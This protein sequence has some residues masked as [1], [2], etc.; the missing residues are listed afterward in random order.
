MTDD[1]LLPNVSS[2]ES[3]EEEEASEH[4]YAFKPIIPTNSYTMMF[5]KSVQTKRCVKNVFNA[6]QKTKAISND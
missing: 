4:N 1:I 5:S 3:S 6:S 2:D